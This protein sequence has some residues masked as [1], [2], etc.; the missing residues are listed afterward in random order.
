MS[1]LIQD[2]DPQSHTY[3]P[4]QPHY[5]RQLG[6]S[7]A[8][9][10]GSKRTVDPIYQVYYDDGYNEGIYQIGVLENEGGNTPIEGI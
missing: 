10:H 2:D 8:A 9:N 3:D 7:D 4:T 5:W 6:H 1:E